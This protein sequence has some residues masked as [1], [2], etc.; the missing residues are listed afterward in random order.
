MRETAGRL[1]RTCLAVLGLVAVVLGA[2]AILLASGHAQSLARSAAPGIQPAA[3][4]D[5]L[6]PPGV[7]DVLASDI[8]AV[9]MATAAVVVG[10]LALLWLLAQIPR[11]HQARAFRLHRD[12]G[13]DG[14]TRC[15]PQVVAGAVEAEAEAIPGVNSASVLLRGSSTQPEV[16][17]DLRVDDRADLQDI[18]RRIHE[19]VAPN[20]ESALEAPLRK[21]GVLFNVSAHRASERSAVL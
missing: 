13:L 18:L 4:G 7:Q 15:G 3:P 17:L 21:I 2:V 16:T 6:L 10:I 1:N 11:R 8:A 20:L 12:D 5:H 19:D 9:I 14:Y